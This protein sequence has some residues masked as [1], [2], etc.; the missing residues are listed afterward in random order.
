[1]RIELDWMCR[2]EKEEGH[3]LVCCVVN[4]MVMVMVLVMVM[5]WLWSGYGYGYGYGLVLVLVMVMVWLWFWLWSGY[6]YHMLLKHVS[7]QRLRV[8]GVHPTPQFRR[9]SDERS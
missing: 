3:T 1:M 8:K 4:V 9:R 7:F 2:R 5:V 6:G